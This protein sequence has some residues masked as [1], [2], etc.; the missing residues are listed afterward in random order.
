MRRV[1]GIDLRLGGREWLR[2]RSVR[3]GRVHILAMLILLIWG[4]ISI[5]TVSVS[6]LRI[7]GM[8]WRLL[9]GKGLPRGHLLSVGHGIG[10]EMASAVA[11]VDR[12]QRPL[13]CTSV[14]RLFSS[15]SISLRCK[16]R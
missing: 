6:V 16:V 11:E 14:D 4:I 2:L 9:A 5:G 7:H 15:A 3:I 8:L 13:R 1:V 12:W 10:G